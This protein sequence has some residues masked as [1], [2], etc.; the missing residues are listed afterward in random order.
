M[1][2]G[3]GQGEFPEKSVGGWM[4]GVG[5]ATPSAAS[6]NEE[7]AGAGVGL[8]GNPQ[9]PEGA[10]PRPFLGAQSPREGGV[11][12]QLQVGDGNPRG[13]CVQSPGGCF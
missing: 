12:L 11:G 2:V 7:L 10:G 3:P 9:R 8:W 13:P 5:V 4:A 6:A 1:R